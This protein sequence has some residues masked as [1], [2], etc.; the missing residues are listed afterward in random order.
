MF[1]TRCFSLVPYTTEQMFNLIN[2]IDSYN[3][4]IPGLNVIKIIQQNSNELIAEINLISNGIIQSLIT[5]NFFV[6]N[7]SI[8]IF[9]I[10][11]PFKFYYG[12][13]NFTSINNVMCR[14]EYIAYYEFQSVLTEKICKYTF[15]KIG[16]NITKIFI[17]RADQIYGSI[18]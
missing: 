10:K 1:H 8:L 16:E 11:S 7:K 14:I 6:K 18:K 9:L 12:C 5:H 17:A 4:F 13:W 3:Q 2:D 15:Q